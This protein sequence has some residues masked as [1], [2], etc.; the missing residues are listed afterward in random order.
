[1]KTIAI[2]L[3]ALVLSLTMVF[4]QQTT[5]APGRVAAGAAS[6]KVAGQLYDSANGQQIRQAVLELAGPVIVSTVSN[7]DGSFSFEVPPG[8]YTLAIRRDRYLP[9]KVT[10]VI[11]TAGEL[12]DA[13]TVMV[14]AGTVTVVNVEESATAV[15]S[16]AAAALAERRL[17]PMVSDTM[18]SEEIRKTVASDAAGALEKVTG[19]SI[20]GN[21]F[22]YVRGLGERYSATM[23]NNAM[24]P[25]TEPE[26]RVV[27][28]DLF[29]AAMIDSIKVLKSY[30]PDLPGEFSGGLVQLQTIEFPTER[31]LRVS[32]S[33]GFNSKTTFKKF[34]THSG[35][36]RDFFGFEDGTRA[37]PSAVPQD[38]RLF[39][40][41][42]TQ[43]Q[44]QDIGR[45][46]ANNWQPVEEDSMRPNQTYS[47]V[48][49]D[50]FGKLGIIGAVT[51]SNTPQRQSELQRYLTNQG[52]NQAII[53]TDYP[54]FT[55]DT[56][57]AR[58]G[59]ILN[60]AYRINPANKISFRN[61]LTRDTDKETRF[62]Q[63]FNG[64]TDTIVNSER[65]RWI[66]RQLLASG[67]E[68]EHSLNSWGNSLIKWQFTY[69]R[70]TRDEPD[71]REVFREPLETGEN[72][73]LA[74]PS[75][76]L[77]FF[78][79]LKDRIYEPQ[80]EFGK[81]FFKGPIT[82]IFRFGFRGT[83]RSR[84]F[85][86][87]RFRFVPV[88]LQTL[89]RALPSDQ[90][91]APENIRPDGFEIRENTRG[92]DTYDANMDVYAGFGL[93]D[94]SLGGRWRLIGGARVEDAL[95][96]VNTIDPLVPGSIP[97]TARLQNR[98]IL[99][100]VNAVYSLGTRQNLR[101]AYGRTV[102]RPDFRE[103][104][105]FDFTNVLGGFNVVG[106]PNLLR[107]RID[108][109]DARWEFFPGG[110]Q[111]I[112]ASFFL[113]NFDDPIEPN[114]QPTTSDL[115]Q[116]FINAD[117]ARNYGVELEAR[118]G[119]GFLSP[120]L[121]DFTVHGNLTLVSSSVTIPESQRGLL[122]SLERPLTGQSRFVYNAIAEWSRLDWRS[123]ARFYLNAVSRRISEVGA[124]GLPDIYQQRNTFVDFVY[125][126][127][128]T[129]NGRLKIR[130][131]AENLT[132]NTFLWTQ[133]DIAQR[134]FQLGRTFRI[135][136]T[137][138]VF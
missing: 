10:D 29:P 27:P 63:G 54:D 50:T 52:G 110:D 48:A 73:F 61:T 35:G 70:S 39:P 128:L 43:Q 20:V 66:E 11:V 109:F 125:E 40:G 101:F 96:E 83:L 112:A 90:L 19:V 6:G 56:E 24:L 115:R 26:R 60:A 131:D 104:S 37:L 85:S 84:D 55:T 107:T 15:A 25:S 14:S 51:F 17:A 129:A 102:A 12:T 9:T 98:D 33:F 64:G 44:F 30:T 130:F 22:V 80:A 71:L 36:S 95:I 86:A 32:S 76:G 21:G 91:F 123:N 13:S 58:L 42:F 136:T 74:L 3:C 68:G 49:G 135:G 5:S 47:V 99:P 81:P 16:S 46:L 137:F 53:L 120:K 94:I 72:S 122:T 75:S 28:L 1:M 93:L 118:K 92:T 78:N 4:G 100:G 127:M 105:P 69:S 97:T 59:A 18:S 7:N 87:R 62:F 79:E 111:L 106:N 65:L 31:T 77:R 126:Y 2:A 45:S 103:L 114:I 119:L 117:S 133:Q 134:R 41:R 67:V 132:D 82:G 38:D 121:R 8:T 57:S 88:R 116:S 138:S 34:R 89:D 108:N 113:K 124:V 23:M